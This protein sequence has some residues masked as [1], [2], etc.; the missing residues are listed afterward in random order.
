MGAQLGGLIGLVSGII[1]GLIALYVGNK[2]AKARRG[3]DEVHQ[4]IWQK[5]RATSW[6]VT[7]ISIYV[8][9]FFV[10]LGF[11]ISAQKVLSALMIL[12]L[13]SWGLLGSFFSSKIYNESKADKQI[14]VFLMIYFS[15]LGLIAIILL[16]FIMK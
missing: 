9:F 12:H 4:H 2:K 7:L 8:M 6:Y 1:I 3:L 10:L 14:Y 13:F 11:P 15:L 16:F 5:A